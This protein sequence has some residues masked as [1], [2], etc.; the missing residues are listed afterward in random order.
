MVKV[1]LAQVNPTVG[2]DPA[3]IDAAAWNALLAA[4]PSPTP[5]ARHEYLSEIGRAHV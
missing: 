4:Q 3:A 2:E 1:A 5:F